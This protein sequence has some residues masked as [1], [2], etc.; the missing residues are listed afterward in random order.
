MKIM[1]VFPEMTLKPPEQPLGILYLASC[2]QRFGHEVKVVDMTPMSLDTDS[3]MSIMSDFQPRVV[4]VSSMITTT[5]A[6][7]RIAKAIKKLDIWDHSPQ[8]WV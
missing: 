3:L 7:C 6:A 5:K 1:L 4:G 2:L 8:Q